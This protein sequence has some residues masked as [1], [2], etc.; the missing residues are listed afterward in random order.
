M[1]QCSD[2]LDNDGDGKK[3]YPLDPGCDSPDDDTETDPAT[4]PKCANG[5]DDDGDGKIDYAADLSCWAASGTAEAFCNPETDRVLLLYSP[6]LT[7]TTTGKHGNYTPSCQT[8]SGLDETYALVLPVAV[9]S[10]TLDTIGSSFDTVLAMTTSTCLPAN[11]LGCND[12]G[13]GVQ[14]VLTVSNVAA[15]T[16]AVVVD[17]F[18]T[19]AGAYTLHAH[20]TVASG[21]ACTAEL[22]TTGVLACPAGTT[23]S[24]TPATCH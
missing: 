21:T 1:A 13:S 15:G 10:L 19:N 2:G 16:Y 23:C 11:E 17:G 20:G 12:D 22:F 14:S 8:S 3:D 18:S 7:G 4:A 24:G 9:Q 6:T 5:I